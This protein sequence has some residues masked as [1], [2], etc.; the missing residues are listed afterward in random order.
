MIADAVYLA[1]AG[2]D[3]CRAACRSISLSVSLGGLGAAMRGLV[4]G[5]G[6]GRVHEIVEAR[7][8]ALEQMRLP[9]APT[10][11]RR[12]CDN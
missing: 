3:L 11:Y 8:K 4:R 2:L 6:R 12:Q 5:S 1:F 7:S 9:F 10:P